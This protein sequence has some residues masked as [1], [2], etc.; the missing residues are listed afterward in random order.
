V[1]ASETPEPVFGLTWLK[2]FENDEVRRFKSRK[3]R[4]NPV[5]VAAHLPGS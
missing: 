4:S 3:I 2:Q 1:P 5:A